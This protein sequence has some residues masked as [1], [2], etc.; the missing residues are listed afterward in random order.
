MLAV[1]AEAATVAL[2]I[3]EPAAVIDEALS[4]GVEA[5]LKHA[6]PGHVLRRFLAASVYP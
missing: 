2:L 1:F 5:P 3:G 6:P 4:F